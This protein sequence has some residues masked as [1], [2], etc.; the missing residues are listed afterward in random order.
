LFGSEG[1]GVNEAG[2]SGD[3]APSCAEPIAHLAILVVYHLASDADI[4]L[5]RLHLDRIARHTSVPYTLYAVTNRLPEG[6]AALVGAAPNVVVCEVPATSLRGSREHGYYLDALLPVALRGPATHVC[7]L[8]VD[9]FPIDDG[10]LDSL[11]ALMPADSGLVGVLRAE[12]GDVT[13]PHPSC[14]LA[15]RD[16]FDRF[17]VTFSPEGDGTDTHQRF[18]RATGQW[19]DTGVALAEALWAANLPWGE[20]RRT[21]TVDE[22]YLLGGIYADAVFHLGG[23][24]RGKVF[25]R[26]LMR[27][28]VHRMTRP[29]EVLPRPGRSLAERMR[30]PAERRLAAENRAA[31]A[32]ITASLLD[33]PDMLFARLRGRPVADGAVRETTPRARA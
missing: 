16:F 27:S 19:P 21:N 7:T 18:L 29:L 8:D 25:R 24:T 20:L 22:H 10:W 23:V 17:P 32:R 15:R 3:A 33:D 6:A 13:L 5:L 26:D 1:R 12:N 9:S 14:I 4:P 28:R 30:R 31:Y 2:R 11:V